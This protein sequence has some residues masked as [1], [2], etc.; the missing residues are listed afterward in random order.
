MRPETRPPV[1]KPPAPLTAWRSVQIA[2]LAGSPKR[3]KIRAAHRAQSQAEQ[4][5]DTINGA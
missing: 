5:G 2:L 4:R 1:Q 3:G